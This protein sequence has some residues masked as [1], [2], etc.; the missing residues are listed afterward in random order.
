MGFP[1]SNDDIYGGDS[2]GASHPDPSEDD[3]KEQA[4]ALLK[5][6]FRE[7]CEECQKYLEWATGATNGTW[8]AQ[9]IYLH[10]LR[11]RTADG[12]FDFSVPEPSWATLPNTRPGSATP[13]R[14]LSPTPPD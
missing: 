11:Y 14:K 2:T 7:G 1:I 5:A 8:N 9:L 4:K 3:E 6:N 10:A 12:K 13:E